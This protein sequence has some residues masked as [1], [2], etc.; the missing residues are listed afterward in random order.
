MRTA[1]AA[2]LGASQSDAVENDLRLLSRDA[3]PLVRA[4][5]LR[6]IGARFG[7]HPE[8]GRRAAALGLLRV[9]LAD[10]APVALT[11]LQI[12]RQVGRGE[13]AHVVAALAR[14]EV[15]VVQE[16]VRCLG[17]I[18]AAEDLEVLHALVAHPD[19]SV[20]AEA[21]QALA[22]RRSQRAIPAILRRLETEQDEFVREVIL[23]ALRR[24]EG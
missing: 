9:A 15:E 8:P 14:P 20:R 18:G 17:T 22:E 21:I 13:G 16:A 4:A 19:W 24:L 2:A 23:A 10:E 5:A 1:A 12:L 7:E 6:A 11:A 3:D